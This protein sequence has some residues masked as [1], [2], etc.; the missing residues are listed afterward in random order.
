MLLVVAVPLG[1][2]YGYTAEYKVSLAGSSDAVSS[3]DIG[4]DLGVSYVDLT[5]WVRSDAPNVTGATAL[6]GWDR[7]AGMGPS[8]T[9]LDNELTGSLA[10][11]GNSSFTT[12]IT[13][14]LAGGR[15]AA[16]DRLYG[17]YYAANMPAG[18]TADLSAWTALFDVRITNQ[19]LA[20]GETYTIK[21]WDNG[22][23]IL[24][25]EGAVT[26]EKGQKVAPGAGSDWT[27]DVVVTAAASQI[28][29][30]ANGDG[31]VNQLDLNAVIDN[32]QANGV[33]W[34]GGDFN[35]DGVVNQLDLNVIIDNW[36]STGMTI[37]EALAGTIFDTSAPQ[38]PEEST[39]TEDV[40]SGVPCT[41][42]GMILLLTL[43][44]A[45]CW[46]GSSRRS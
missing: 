26:Y 12:L 29:G 13:S 33:G 25:Y 30:D 6:L 46:L 45:G 24:N 28:P 1:M 14:Q 22:A 36:Q 18:T 32:W 38:A 16:G 40:S 31:V 37:Q 27:Y 34:A 5:I 20:V 44:F 17:T 19:G 42:L 35:G 10:T 2:A 39:G 41:A 11:N 15:K 21:L 7:A 4:T 23:T 43:G 8:A 9:P 3:V